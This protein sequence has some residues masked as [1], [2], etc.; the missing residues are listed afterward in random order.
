M[1]T[2]VLYRPNE[3][4]PA[5]GSRVQRQSDDDQVTLVGDPMCQMREV[6]PPGT[7][8]VQGVR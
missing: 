7:S 1:K 5:G 6:G 3:G 8:L 2:P 4:F